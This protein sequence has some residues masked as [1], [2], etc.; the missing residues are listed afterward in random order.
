MSQSD[1]QSNR[2][3]EHDPRL[4][5]PEWLRDEPAEEPPA[6]GPAMIA[7]PAAAV[8][9]DVN[10]AQAITPARATWQAP[11]P[12]VATFDPATLIAPDD[13]PAWIRSMPAPLRTTDD[14][15]EIPLADSKLDV[16]EEVEVVVAQGPTG[17]EDTIDTTSTTRPESDLTETRFAL[18][19]GGAL[20]VILAVI[21]LFYF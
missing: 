15:A 21:A 1:P 7:E 12:P 13:L 6:P 10:A 5:L 17:I 2:P 9:S 14:S 16:V 3:P 20:V 18:L 4:L 11:P 19:A 8:T